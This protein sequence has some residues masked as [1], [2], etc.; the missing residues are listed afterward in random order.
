[1]SERSP[2]IPASPRYRVAKKTSALEAGLPRMKWLQRWKTD[3]YLTHHDFEAKTTAQALVAFFSPFRSPV[4]FAAP[5]F[6]RNSLPLATKSVDNLVVAVR[7]L[8]SRSYKN[9]QQ[10]LRRFPLFNTVVNT[11]RDW[12]IE[13]TNR[14]VDLLQREPRTRTFADL[15]PLAIATLKPLFKLARLNLH[16]HVLP[17]LA[18]M[19]ESAKMYLTNQDERDRLAQYYAIARDELPI[20]FYEVKHRFYPVLLKLLSDKLVEREHFFLDFEPQILALLDLKEDDLVV[21][22][23]DADPVI[24]EPPPPPAWDPE[25]SRPP[26]LAL[27]GLELLNKLFPRAGWSHLETHPDLFSYFQTVFEYPR[28]ADLVAV[29][30]P[31]QVLVPL[32][33]ILQHLFYGFQNIQWGT[34]KNHV[35]DPI[36]VQEVI[37]KR[38]SRWHF[39]H[40]E[41]FGKNYLSL[42][43]E[44]CRE[45]ERSG[46]LSTE[47]KRHENLLL[48]FQRNY[49]LPNKILPIMDG[50]R[51]KTL[52]YP[53]L[54]IQIREMLELLAPIAVDVERNGLRSTA[55]LN[56]EAKV[57]FPVSSLVNQRFLSVLRSPDGR[58]LATNRTLLFYVLALLTT[59]NDLVSRANSQLYQSPGK[60]LYRT[61]GD[62]KPVYN[63][64][65]KNSL[66][67]LKKL[68]D[69]ALAD[70]VVATV[71]P[72]A[73]YGPFMAVEELRSRIQDHQED[74]KP[75]VLVAFRV[76][77]PGTEARFED[78][79][80][81]PPT[82]G[83]ALFRQGDGTW[84]GVMADTLADKAEVYVREI[85]ELAAQGENPI[86]LGGLVIPFASHWNLEKLLAIPAKGWAEAATVSPQALG[87]WNPTAQNFEFRT[88]VKTV[89]PAPEAVTAD[90]LP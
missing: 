46:P 14:E 15:G 62:D 45:I 9:A 37:E 41:F 53:N 55:L 65:K 90:A 86:G 4:D 48:W 7:G 79:M 69:Q 17:A 58:E 81:P 20:V 25:P 6:V 49:L 34:L 47:A 13:A 72:A 87:V 74:K 73:F 77:F 28:G 39:F 8:S 32:S 80:D 70:R 44:Y 52:G 88:D 83:P 30:D 2:F 57:R 16:V 5:R 11:L 89:T 76:W 1:V 27:E 40:E 29:D 68:N 43:Q 24:T 19:Y 82:G 50:V 26:A 66:G 3:F 21:D 51:V 18:K 60:Y 33:E 36:P 71:D 67:L 54:P 10:H 38:V 12:D 31:V 84:L 64:P 78:L 63:A 56:P 85:L 61:A 59:L 75:F 23:P 22:H 42:L 35:G